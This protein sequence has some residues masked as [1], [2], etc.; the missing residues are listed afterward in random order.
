[1]RH[2]KTFFDNV[3]TNIV[4]QVKVLPHLSRFMVPR[5]QTFTALKPRNGSVHVLI[6]ECYIPKNIHSVFVI[7]K[8]VVPFNHLLRHFFC[9]VPRPKLGTI[10]VSKL[11]NVVMIKMG[12]TI[13]P[14]SAAHF[15]SS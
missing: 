8:L 3:T 12:I 13:Y 6:R 10:I 1:M 9:V 5:D 15:I 2:D 11:A 7:N 14:S 4:E